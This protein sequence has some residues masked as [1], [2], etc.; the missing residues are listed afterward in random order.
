MNINE[1]LEQAESIANQQ[2]PDD[3]ARFLA[4]HRKTACDNLQNDHAQIGNLLQIV[5]AQIRYLNQAGF[6]DKASGIAE[7]FL[8][9]LHHLQENS[10]DIEWKHLKL[11]LRD[12]F[13][14]F[15][16]HYASSLAHLDRIEDMRIAMRQALDLTTM[17]PMAIVFLIHLY[18]PLLN[19]ETLENQPSRQWILDRYAECL[20]LLDFAGL[21]DT[22]FRTALDLFQLAI[23]NPQQASSLIEQ[24]EQ[25]TQSA[26]NDIALETLKN[27]LL[28]TEALP[29]KASQ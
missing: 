11:A 5:T 18:Q 16:R 29:H 19:R 15:F 25:I 14:A 9:I 1:I 26:P 24:V 28:H 21:H 20:A 10:P 23:R 3:A 8:H 7:W 4:E 13:S 12:S 17:L 2:S 22:P 27:M 6:F